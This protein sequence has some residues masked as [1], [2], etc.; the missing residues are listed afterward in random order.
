MAKRTS[1]G[2]G[3]R[4]AGITL[5]RH[6]NFDQPALGGC[7]GVAQLVLCL[8]WNNSDDSFEQ[9]GTRA[10][11]HDETTLRDNSVTS[12]GGTVHKGGGGRPE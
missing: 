12:Q 5:E 1:H 11:L 10:I 6:L 9:D 3:G 8:E 2:V 7:E 4:Q